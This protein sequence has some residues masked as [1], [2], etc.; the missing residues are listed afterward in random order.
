MMLEDGSTVAD[1]T[2][3]Y[4]PIPASLLERMV[5]SWPGFAEFTGDDA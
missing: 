2:G 3:T 1:A 5:G 4:L